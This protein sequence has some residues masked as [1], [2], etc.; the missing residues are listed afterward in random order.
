M[1]WRGRKR[2]W[3]QGEVQLGRPSDSVSPPLSPWGALEL[4]WPSE[5]SYSSLKGPGLYTCQGS[6]PECGRLGKGCG[7]KP[8]ALCSP[9][10]PKGAG[11]KVCLL[12]AS[13]FLEEGPSGR[14]QGLP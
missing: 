4:Q 13:S 3:A 11:A 5:S 6:V 12:I 7:I 2:V 10:N 9:G 8:G 14:S 1:E